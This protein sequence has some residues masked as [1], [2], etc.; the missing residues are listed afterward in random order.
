MRKKLEADV[1][2]PSYRCLKDTW[3]HGMYWFRGQVYDD[4]ARSRGVPE[5]AQ[6]NAAWEIVGGIPEGRPVRSGA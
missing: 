5:P 2:P 3:L 4:L 6:G 1:A